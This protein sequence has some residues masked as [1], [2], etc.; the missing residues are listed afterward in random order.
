MIGE[1]VT[2][3]ALKLI[4]RD[5]ANVQQQNKQNGSQ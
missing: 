5:V 3:G 4:I 2:S 1:K